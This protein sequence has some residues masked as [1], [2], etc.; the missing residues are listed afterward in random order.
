MKGTGGMD[1]IRNMTRAAPAASGSSRGRDYR[2]HRSPPRR[3][4]SRDRRG[5]DGR[6]EGSGRRRDR[7]G[8]RHN[9]GGNRDSYRGDSR[10]RKR[11]RDDGR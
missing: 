4:D 5:G 2:D 10:D 3:G 8:E 9:V 6:S 7:S 1:N 11:A